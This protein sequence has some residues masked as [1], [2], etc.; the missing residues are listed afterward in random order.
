MGVTPSARS[1]WWLTWLLVSG[2]V[3]VFVGERLFARSPT[4]RIAFTG[5]GVL[6]I[7]GSSAWRLIAWRRTSG[8]ARSVEGLLLLTHVGCLAALALYWVGTE[9]GL[10]VLDLEFATAEAE[11]RFETGL[12]VS[13]SLLLALSLLSALGAAWA[14]GTRQGG[15]EA[16]EVEA[17]R[18]REAA[19]TGLTVAMAG[20][21]LLL[22]GWVASDRDRTLDLSYFRTASPGTST[23]EVVASLE[24][25]LRVTMFFPEV[26]AVKDEVLT[27]FSA[28]ADLTGRV[29]IEVF[30]GMEVPELARELTVSSDGTVL[31][32][33]GELEERIILES[34][35]AA[36]R[37]TLRTLDGEVQ[38]LLLRLVRGGRIVYLTAGH[39]EMND[40]GSAGPTEPERNVGVE[41]FREILRLL[42]YEA[43]DLAV[44]TGLGRDVPDDAAA[45]V[46]LGP[47][48]PFLEE[49]EAA[50]DRY[51]DRGGSLLLAID[52]ETDVDFPLLTRRLGV[53]VNRAPLADDTQ[54]LQRRGNAS[55][56]RLLVTD[57]FTSHAS[58]STLSRAPVG[59]G[60][61]LLGVGYLEEVPSDSGPSPTFVMRTLATTFVDSD[62]DFEFD[63]D[64]EV[65]ESKPVAAAIES[66]PGGSQGDE[67]DDGPAPA[68]RALV[69]AD[70]DLFSDLVLRSFGLNGAL[71]ADAI[72]WLGNEEDL[73][74]ETVSEEDMPIQHTRAQNVA[75]F[76]STIVGAPVLTLAL[77]L[78]GVWARRRRKGGARA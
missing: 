53:E 4:Y 67:E 45:V 54:F 55:D 63:T 16:D 71:V 24:E 46:V 28:L 27:Y 15:E 25:P 22:L 32:R 19:A 68:M 11:G 30:D 41:G 21:A 34:D 18:V 26:N 17:L 13:W 8:D 60:I 75:W 50:L 65:R 74:G 69:Y 58:V 33:S 47:R 48:R 31:L 62:A 73:A 6:I 12:H 29:E 64:S 49:E 66:S 51:L 40:P 43:R 61:A 38:S 56:H 44:G 1:P 78:L 23:R 20:A 10:S 42:N 59:T 3:L 14:M 70:A 77:G 36:A 35:L 5:L 9:S 39:G 2:L 72:R 7:L 76:Y 52:P 37:T 57:R